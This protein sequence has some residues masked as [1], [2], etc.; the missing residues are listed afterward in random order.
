MQYREWRYPCQH[1]VDLATGTQRVQGLMVNVSQHGARIAGPLSTQTGDRL[2]VLLGPGC[3]PREAVVRWA[4]GG[5]FGVN[6]ARPLD[7]RTIA[8]VRKTAGHRGFHGSAPVARAREL[9]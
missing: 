4:R 1:P 6:F 9:R 3:L 5:T 8:V 7:A 2:T